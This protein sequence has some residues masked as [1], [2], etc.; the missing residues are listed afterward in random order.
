MKL[1]KLLPIVFLSIAGLAAC[2]PKD[3]YDINFANLSDIVAE[4]HVGDADRVLQLEATKN[5]EA[6]NVPSLLN[7]EIFVTSSNTDVLGTVGL[8]LKAVSAGD[9]T[10]KVDYHGTTLEVEL[11]IKPV[12]TCIDKYGTVHAGTEADPLDY[13]D[14]IEIGKQMKAASKSTGTDEDDIYIKGVVKTWYHFPGERKGNDEATSWFIEGAEGATSASDLFEMYKITKA[15]GSSLTDEDIWPGAEVLIKGQIGYY[16]S[17]M[18]TTKGTFVRVTGGAARVAPELKQVG[19][20]TKDTGALAIGNALEDGDTTWDRYEITGYTVNYLGKNGSGENVTHNYMIADSKTE[21]NSAK[22][23]EIYA[24]KTELKYQEKVKV[25]C[26]IKNYHKTI[27]TNVLENIEVLEAGTDWVEY[28]EPT[29]IKDKGLAD[30]FADESGNY[31]QAYEVTGIVSKWDSKNGQP[32]ED[33]TKYGNFYLQAEGDNGEYYIYG[34]SGTASALSWGK[35]A[36]KYSFV[37]PQDFLTNTLTKDIKIGSM[38][39]MKLV[40]C[41]YTKD[42]NT[43]KEA[44]GIVLEV[45]T[46]LAKVESDVFA[47]SFTADAENSK[48]ATYTNGTLSFTLD[49]NESTT[50]NRLSDADHLRIYKNA[51]FTVAF[52]G[53]KIAKIQFVCTAASYA[54][55]AN[56]VLGEG[57]TADFNDKVVIVTCPENITSMSFVAGNQVRINKVIVSYVAADAA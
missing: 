10:L 8:V 57:F 34:A 7:T 29:V 15:D 46:P 54:A 42:G 4:W 35:Y 27:E 47:T 48:L 56:W 31:K 22:M 52:S 49:Q 17:Q 37:N 45:G 9:A 11:G 6:V 51:K 23:F 21:T 14:A 50:A 30:L 40:R 33:G 36:N 12:R 55:E 13:A 19:V 25:T 38:V 44:T 20:S 1:R 43:T 41:D 26:R 32:N 18:E 24:S 39:T 2:G 53:G 28:D 3:V 5:G 16:N